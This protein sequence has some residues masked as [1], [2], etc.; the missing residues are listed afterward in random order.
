MDKRIKSMKNFFEH[1]IEDFKND[2]ERFEEYK[3]V[4]EALAKT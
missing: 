3:E 1:F 2:K 4:M